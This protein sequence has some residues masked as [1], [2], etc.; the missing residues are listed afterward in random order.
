M[1]GLYNKLQFE[2]IKNDK[3]IQNIAVLYSRNQKKKKLFL[4]LLQNIQYNIET[5]KVNNLINHRE[6]IVI[7]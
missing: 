5:Y 2:N 1:F 7:S 6:K 3:L 4:E